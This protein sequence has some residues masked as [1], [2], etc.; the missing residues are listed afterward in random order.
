MGAELG[1]LKP[2]QRTRRIYGCSPVA[3]IRE[4]GC[5]CCEVEKG[6]LQVDTEP[7]GS[8]PRKLRQIPLFLILVRIVAEVLRRALQALALDG[9]EAL[10]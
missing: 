2:R 1:G 8:V 10:G 7:E 5:C 6:A 9:V 4:T 3:R